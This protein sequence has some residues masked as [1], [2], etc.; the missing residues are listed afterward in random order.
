LNNTHDNK[1]QEVRSFHEQKMVEGQQSYF[2]L[3][4]QGELILQ[5]N[6]K[7]WLTTH[8]RKAIRLLTLEPDDIFV[9]VGCGEGYLTQALSSKAKQSLR[10]DFSLGALRVLNH[11]PSFDTQRLSLALEPGACLRKRPPLARC[12]C[13]QTLVQSYA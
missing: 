12:Q 3:D 10:L 6:Q 13:R 7:A 2:T 4:Q 8:L 5:T 9:D 1:A 11:R